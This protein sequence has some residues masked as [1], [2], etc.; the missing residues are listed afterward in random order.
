MCI[1][2]LR[3]LLLLLCVIIVHL[4]E[5]HAQEAGIAVCSPPSNHI[6]IVLHFMNGSG[7]LPTLKGG[8]KSKKK[9]CLEKVG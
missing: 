2:M 5:N 9:W 7:R 8:K 4:K 1:F 6:I 3:I